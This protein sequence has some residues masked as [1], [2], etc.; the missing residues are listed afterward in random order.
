MKLNHDEV[1]VFTGRLK[2][3]CEMSTG[4]EE[5]SQS[6]FTFSFY[7]VHVTHF[8]TINYC[9]NTNNNVQLQA[10]PQHNYVLFISITQHY[11]ITQLREHCKVCS[12]IKMQL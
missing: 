2:N 3:Y 8:D 12:N 5:K 11:I 6:C 4:K 10:A 7:I 1:G 9:S